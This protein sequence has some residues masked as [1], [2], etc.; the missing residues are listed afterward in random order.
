MPENE[1]P[2]V[3][4][5]TV[6]LA[7]QSPVPPTQGATQISLAVN[8]HEVVLTFGI[9]RATMQPDPS[10]APVPI[11]GIGWLISLSVPPTAAKMLQENLAKVLERYEEHFG[12]IP[13]DPNAR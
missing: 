2:A 5:G 9:S 3:P 11:L 7:G 4:V 10:G 6:N 13:V 12:K 1:T 8:L